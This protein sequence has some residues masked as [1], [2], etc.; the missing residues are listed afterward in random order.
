MFCFGNGIGFEDCK[1]MIFWQMPFV[2]CSP[3]PREC[4]RPIKNLHYCLH[5]ID[6]IY[7][8][9]HVTMKASFIFICIQF[10]VTN[11]VAVMKEVEY[12]LLAV[13]LS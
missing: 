2:I 13:T 12:S 8:F 11:V 1:Q 4:H 3:R 5:L 7:G 6:A 10:D 9:I